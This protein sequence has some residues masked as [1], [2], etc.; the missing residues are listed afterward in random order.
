MPLIP[1]LK[2]GENNMFES[3]SS[4]YSTCAIIESMNSNNVPRGRM[5]RVPFSVAACPVA[6]S[7]EFLLE[8]SFNALLGG[9][10]RIDRDVIPVRI[11]E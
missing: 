1:N 6:R 2:D 3:F 10:E 5:D 4:V 11:S 9:R 8:G 7:K